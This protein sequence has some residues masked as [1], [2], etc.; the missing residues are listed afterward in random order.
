MKKIYFGWHIVA[1]TLLLTIHNCMLFSYGFTAFV[2]PIATTFGWSVAQVSLASSLRGVEIG[3]LDPLVGMMSDRWSA[4]KLVFIGII[5][6]AAGV[7]CYTRAN[8]LYIFYLGFLLIGFGSA[9]SVSMVPI[10]VVSRWFK[11]DI[12]KVNGILATGIT[13]GGL[14][15]PLV[16]KGIDALGWQNFLLYMM[17]GLV[18]IGLPASFIFLDRPR[19]KD[20][21]GNNQLSDVAGKS[22]T[23]ETGIDLK[24]AIKTK[25]F[26]LISLSL[27]LQSVALASVSVHLMPYL[28]SL[29]MERARAAVALTIFAA[30]SLG[31]RLIY[32]FLADIFPK[33]Y[34]MVISC[35]IMSLAL[36]MF[37]LLS[38]NSFGMVA[39][40]AVVYAV[41][42]GGHT[43]LRAP[44]IREYF[45]V[46]KFGSIY[47]IAM[48]LVMLSGA[49]CIPIT[50]WYYD[51]YGTYY[52]VWFV[53]AGLAMISAILALW[54]PGINKDRGIS[55]SN[56][57][58]QK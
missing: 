15:A 9:L 31:S 14:F 4:R 46:K 20:L 16:V 10:T 30:V 44:I 29:G 33:K 26:W 50:G 39:L 21:D 52:P 8:S 2:N 1:V 49:V 11:K 56:T 36:V 48:F 57:L 58:I 25:A 40:F 18:I 28:T 24:Q 3:V 38:G 32:G 34:V 23:T 13:L 22:I 55:P 17:V 37:G 41:G 53:F 51:T 6:T 35:L 43:P 27:T 47:G 7:V 42:A 19:K 5:I 45:G 12:G 54:L